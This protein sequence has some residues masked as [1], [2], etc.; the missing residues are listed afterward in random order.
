MK[1]LK[2]PKFEPTSDLKFGKPPQT[3]DHVNEVIQ[4]QYGIKA[5]IKQEQKYYEL[6][7]KINEDKLKQEENKKY[8]FLRGDFKKFDLTKQPDL[9][10]EV[11]KNF[12]NP[13]P[14]E[15]TKEKFRTCFIQPE[16]KRIN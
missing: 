14:K 8:R 16:L 13:Q 15:K 5:T 11:H 4:F 12:Y 2:Y 3:S 10:S 6:A 7:N 1:T 9:A